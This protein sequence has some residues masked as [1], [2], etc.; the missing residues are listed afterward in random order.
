MRF[1]KVGLSLLS[2]LVL[3]MILSLCFLVPSGAITEEA[4]RAYLNALPEDGESG[5]IA[6]RKP[7][8]V[9][10]SAALS[11]ILPV[12][13]ISALPFDN[14]PGRAPIQA[15]FTDTG[16]RDDTLIVEMEQKRMFDSDVFVAYVKIATPSQLRTAY[17][18]NKIGS[19]RTNQT[20]RLAQNYNA[21]VAI[22]GDAYANP[23]VTGGY[24]IKQGEVFREK[25]SKNMDLLV[26]DELGDFHILKRGH[27]EQAEALKAIKK[28]HEIIN[29]FF[30]GPGLV[31]DGEIQD[32]PENY[33]WNPTG[34]E[35]RAAL[36][37][38]GPLTYVMVVV[39]GRTDTSAGA[40]HKEMAELMAELGC[41][42]A[43]NFDGGNSATMAFNGQV[44][45]D[46]PQAE[47]SIYDIIYFATATE[48]Q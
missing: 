42:Q 13:D 35:P 5:G 32:I 37:Q 10:A 1:S 19:T 8:A 22:N 16:Y 27:D 39:N 46:K 47:R 15:N 3:A 28:E 9:L 34:K 18:G 2:V 23:D 4:N 7:V 21:V 29:C 25:T 30:F 40:T 24:I 6:L 17:A 36:G 48:G 20:S 31:V 45:N 12:N 43:Y 41:R 11:D 14:S 44:Y 26:V 33:Q 38:L